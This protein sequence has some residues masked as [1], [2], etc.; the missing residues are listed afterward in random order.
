M[1]ICIRDNYGDGWSASIMHLPCDP[2]QGATRS[3]CLDALEE[4]LK[5][6]VMR[7]ATNLNAKQQEAFRLIDEARER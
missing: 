2:A 3:A 1:R 6:Y 5:R 4:S 7:A